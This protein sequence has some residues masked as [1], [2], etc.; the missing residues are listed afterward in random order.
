MKAETIKIPAEI[1]KTIYVAYGLGR[2]NQGDISFRDYQPKDRS[3]GWEEVEIASQKVKIKI[4]K[5]TAINGRKELVRAYQKQKDKILA[6][7]H[8]EAAK[9]EDEIQRLLAIEYQPNH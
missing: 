5:G 2:Y 8:V 6:Q 1:E 9:I 7:A 4:P 3:K